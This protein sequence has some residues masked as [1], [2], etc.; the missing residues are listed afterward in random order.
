MGDKPNRIMMATCTRAL[1]AACSKADALARCE[2]KPAR[3]GSGYRFV[4]TLRPIKPSTAD[5]VSYAVTS[6]PSAAIKDIA[7]SVGRGKV[8]VHW[9]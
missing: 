7:I 9:E 5:D 6:N 2:T 4:S 1:L 3:A 8:T